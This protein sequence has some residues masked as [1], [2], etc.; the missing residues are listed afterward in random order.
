MKKHWPLFLIAS[1][2]FTL[3]AAP[4]RAGTIFY[5]AIPAAQS[6]ANSGISSDNQYTTAIDGGN[7]RGTDRV[8]NGITLSALSASGQSATADNGTLN[9]LAGNLSNAGGASASIQADGVLKDVLSDMIFNN[10]ATDNSQQEIVLDPS[11][12]QSGTTYDLRVYIA[13]AAGQNRQVNIAFVGD[14]K[15][16]VETGF[17]NEDDAKTSAGGFTDSDQA[18]YIN[19]RFTWDGDSTPGVTITQKAGSA[20]FVLYALTN[21]VVAG[22]GTAEAAPAQEGLT[23]GQV[24][25]ESDKVGVESDDFYTSESLN[26][27]GHWVKLDKWGNCWQPTKVPTGWC[28]YTNGNW[29]ECDDC[30]WTFVSEE[31]WAWACYH[32]GRWAKVK[33]GCGWCWVPGRVWAP[34]WVSWRQ[35]RDEKC[36]CIGWAPLPP[37]Q[38]CDINIGVSTWVDRTCDLGPESYTFCNV[39]DFGSES[40]SGCGCLYE[41]SR[42]IT[43]I[44]ETINI[45]NICYTRNVTYCGGPNFDRCNEQIRRLGGKELTHVS[46]NRVNDPS[47]LKGGKLSHLEGNQLGLVSPNI[48]GDKNSKHN[49]KTTETLGADKRDKGWGNDKK[50]ENTARNHIAQESKGKDPKN[51]KATLPSDLGDRVA[52]KNGGKGGGGNKQTGAGQA[53]GASQNVGQKGQNNGLPNGNAQANGGKHDQHPGGNNKGNKNAGNA[54]AA[55]N[56][57]NTGVVG[58]A[59]GGGGKHPGQSLK[60]SKNGM[61]SS[62][63]AGQTSAAGGNGKP[64]GKNKS[65]NGN[66]SAATSTANTSQGSSTQGSAGQGN[67]SQGGNGKRRKQQSQTH[68]TQ[69]SGAQGGAQA[70]GNQSGGGQG[71]S[72]SGKRHKQA[73]QGASTQGSS[74]GQGGG[75]NGQSNKTQRSMQSGQGSQGGG[76][77]KGGG[78]QGQHQQHQQQPNQQQQGG[79]QNHAK[80]TATPH[81]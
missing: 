57:G 50:Q 38:G 19:Y 49:P 56:T 40:Y 14:G 25:V 41:R 43:I 53:N 1:A 62:G 45:T 74:S 5:S 66:Q 2:V 4:T 69:G 12:L 51:T 33:S 52:K 47:Q 59:G 63:G 64:H 35:G 3:V 9:A 28:P 71:Q 55:A 32:Y 54:N 79:K 6:D 76:G 58:N 24:N 75:G 80:P 18:Y 8:I 68:P 31:P 7:T 77:N 17:F 16:A 61:G 48:K 11:S 81:P 78:G 22:G 44:I 34:S 39:R 26:A 20:P 10:G 72:G 13:N 60:G 46:I 73:N 27:N 42:N 70:S 23:N 65:P 36:S 37:E 67:S 21:Q 30:G 29:R 15:P